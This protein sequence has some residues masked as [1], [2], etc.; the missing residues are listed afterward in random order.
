MGEEDF[1]LAVR[2]F[3]AELTGGQAAEQWEHDRA[4][5]R[6]VWQALGE[7][8]LLGLGYPQRLGGSGVPLLHSVAFLSEL[9]R[10]G[11][12]GFRT[13]VAVHSYMAN[14][15]LGQYGSPFLQRQYLAPALAGR[16]V[17]A[18]AITEP[19]AGSD[20]A[21]LSTLAVP[22][23]EDFLVTGVKSM[24]VNGSAADYFV[25]ACR[26]SDTASDS[27]RSKSGGISLL[28]VDAALPGVTAAPQPTLGWHSAG[29]AT[30]A[31]D[32]VRVAGSQVIGRAGAG[33]YQLLYGLQYERLAAA[34][35]AV[36]GTEHCLQVLVDQLRRRSAHGR[37][38][39]QFQAVRHR[40]AAL[41]TEA[42]AARELVAHAARCFDSAK[43][44]VA[45]CSM[46][47]LYATELASRAA[48]ACLQLH[49][50][51]GYLED[52]IAARL[53]RDTRAATIAAGPTEVMYDLIASSV[54][55]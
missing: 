12:A 37:Q 51:A 41:A 15:Y 45:E 30:V 26:M 17:A 44:P 8:Q 35:M 11:F 4:L 24:V 13:A 38:L 32:G 48:D 22:D 1:R 34:A 42:V 54:L 36:G 3:L 39:A 16:K 21:A 2:A 19:E 46:A 29:T 18:L 43:L 49:G 31:F 40:V 25:L 52:S 28:V 53:L 50:S 10:T 7:N 47:K 55:D 5:P 27:S 14:H 33:F 6:S 23:G 9:G 20:L